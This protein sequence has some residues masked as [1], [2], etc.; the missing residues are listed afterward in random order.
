MQA[1]E[2]ARARATAIDIRFGPVLNGVPACR[3]LAHIVCTHT[4]RAVRAGQALHTRALPIAH[5]T[6][7]GA[8]R[9][10]CCHWRER[11]VPSIAGVYG[12]AIAIV[13]Q[14]R[15]VRII[16]GA[17]ATVADDPLAVARDLRGDGRAKGDTIGVAR[18]GYAN[19]R[20]ALVAW[21]G[22]VRIIVAYAPIWVLA[23]LATAA[24]LAVERLLNLL[25]PA[26]LISHV[27]RIITHGTCA[28]EGN[29]TKSDGIQE[30]T[31]HERDLR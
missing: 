26:F 22:A 29:Q 16:H 1:G 13:R 6:V 12:A 3:S 25:R 11:G 20:Q 30:T 10:A 17:A 2:A 8:A 27:R 18:A 4:T 19:F 28:R 24:L 15:R 23:T 7:S 9:R 31:S 21:I 14:I 5:H